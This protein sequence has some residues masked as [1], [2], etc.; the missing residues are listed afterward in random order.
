MIRVHRRYEF[1]KR[2]EAR[3]KVLDLE[4]EYKLAL[5]NTFLGRKM[6]ITYKNI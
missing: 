4:S 5:E 6:S 2:N 1:G 3:E